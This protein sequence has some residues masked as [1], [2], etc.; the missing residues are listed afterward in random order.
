MRVN[1]EFSEDMDR[2]EEGATKD[3]FRVKIHS[4]VPYATDGFSKR[5]VP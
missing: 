4:A 3:V 1:R 2:N 5:Y